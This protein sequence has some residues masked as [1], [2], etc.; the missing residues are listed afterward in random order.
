MK[1]THIVVTMTISLIFLVLSV[2]LIT[3]IQ[4]QLA[5]KESS[6][7]SAESIMA[8]M[9]SLSIYKSSDNTLV[10]ESQYQKTIVEK[11]TD[12]NY[13]MT[14]I[15]ST[16]HTKVLEATKEGS[17][18][19]VLF[20]GKELLKNPTNT[21]LTDS[22]DFPLLPILSANLA[23]L[24]QDITQKIM[25]MVTDSI[26]HY[27]WD[28]VPFISGG[29]GGQSIKYP[30]P[31]KEALSIWIFGDWSTDG[32]YL[33]HNMFN[34]AASIAMGE[35]G[36]FGISGAIGAAVGVAIGGPWGAA[37]GVIIGTLYGV[38]L[39][40]F[41]G[42]QVQDEDLNIWWWQSLPFIHWVS[43]N[44]W[45]IAALGQYALPFV[46]Y[47]FLTSGY[48]RIGSWTFFN[49]LGISDPAPPP[50]HYYVSSIAQTGTWGAGAVN[51]PNGLI[52]SSNDGSYVQLWGGNPGDGGQ[53]VGWMSQTANG[54]IYLYGHSGPGYYTHLYTFV[55]YNNNYDWTQTSVQTVS[56]TNDRWIDCG[57]YSGNFRYIAIA[58]IDDNGMSANIF[59]DSVKVNP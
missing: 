5:T 1:K 33:Q 36:P 12:T 32:N 28:G 18:T 34:Q 42:Y 53:I 37:A 29:G 57:S 41:Y 43:D 27:N 47:E 45:Y 24:P 51:N 4:G 38:Y 55:S 19:S 35:F 25:P 20:D 31:D 30:H 44:A 48:I 52:G 22:D 40:Y 50:P 7:L 14:F 23:E 39:W 9:K 56:G 59:I 49:A 46:E 26:E 8:A 21:S 6:P 54:H 13:K 16:G 11:I 17:K 2:G 10:I 15:N 58:A 3:P